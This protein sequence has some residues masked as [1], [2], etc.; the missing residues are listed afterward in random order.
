MVP[1]GQ[2]PSV[3]IRKKLQDDENA[4]LVDITEWLT[5]QNVHKIMNDDI[6]VMASE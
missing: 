1:A 4:A 5:N 6:V 3:I 2:R